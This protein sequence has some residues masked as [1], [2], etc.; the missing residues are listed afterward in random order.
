[1]KIFGYFTRWISEK[2]RRRIPLETV[3]YAHSLRKYNTLE[4]KNE[5]TVLKQQFSDV[6]CPNN[7]SI[8]NARCPMDACLQ[9]VGQCNVLA[10]STFQGYVGKGVYLEIMKARK[11]GLPVYL[12]DGVQVSL[13]TEPLIVLGYDWAVRY[14]VLESNYIVS[15]PF[16]EEEE[17][18]LLYDIGEF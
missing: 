17:M 11:L 6:Y 5:Y 1:M 12:V 3:Y 13:C 18:S 10:F 14:A 9:R 4:E 16:M 15:H 7:E 8:Q 2:F